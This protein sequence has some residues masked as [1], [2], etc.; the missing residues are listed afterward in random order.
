M[1]SIHESRF[2]GVHGRLSGK[3]WARASAAVFADL[4]NIPQGDARASRDAG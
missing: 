3:D 2:D 1:Q 4:P